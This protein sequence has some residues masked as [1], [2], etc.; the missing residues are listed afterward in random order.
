MGPRWDLYGGMC[1]GSGLIGGGEGGF[2]DQVESEPLSTR[3]IRRIVGDGV[4]IIPYSDLKNYGS[5]ESLVGSRGAII[6]YRQ[7]PTYGHWVAITPGP[8][9]HMVSYY[10]SYGRNI[11]VYLNKL[12]RDEAAALGQDVPLLTMLI[13]DAISRGAI[14]EVDVNTKA[15]QSKGDMATCGRYAALRVRYKNLTNKE[16]NRMIGDKNGTGSIYDRNVALM[17]A[18]MTS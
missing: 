16:F 18:A 6:L 1:H 4:P 15:A 5:L 3:E 17:T 11:D 2:I 9:S 13:E 8:G 7:R 10:D 12:P 14:R